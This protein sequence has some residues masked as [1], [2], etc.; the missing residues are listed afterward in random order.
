MQEHEED[1]FKEIYS[2]ILTKTNK[3]Y[4]YIRRAGVRKLCSLEFFFTIFS[5]VG[6]YLTIKHLAYFF[7][8]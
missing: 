5:M 1:N 3:C 8:I 4:K 7:Q 2:K 6:F